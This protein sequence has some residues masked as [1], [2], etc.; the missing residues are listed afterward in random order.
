MKTNEISD[1]MQNLMMEIRN[2]DNRILLMLFGS[3]FLIFYWMANVM[4]KPPYFLA[5]YVLIPLFI[6]LISWVMWGS[7]QYNITVRRFPSYRDSINRELIGDDLEKLDLYAYTL[8]R[9]K[10]QEFLIALL[11]VMQFSGIIVITGIT[12]FYF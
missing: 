2:S 12:Y 6:N 10:R 4:T 11:I 7:S 9:K 8:R 3:T 5:I 1:E